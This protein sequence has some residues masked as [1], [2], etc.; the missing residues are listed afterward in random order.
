MD[1][2][3]SINNVLVIL[4]F[5]E[6]NHQVELGELVHYNVTPSSSQVKIQHLG[7]SKYQLMMPYN[8]QINVSIVARLCGQQSKPTI[9]PLNYYSEWYF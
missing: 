7:R 2:S 6:T 3:F 5:N 4:L 9:I 1:Q 8:T